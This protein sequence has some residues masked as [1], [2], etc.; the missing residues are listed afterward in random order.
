MFNALRAAALAACCL[1]RGSP[2]DATSYMYGPWSGATSLDNCFTP[3]GHMNYDRD[4]DPWVQLDLAYQKPLPTGTF[5]T[6]ADSTTLRLVLYGEAMGNCSSVVH[7]CVVA[8]FGAGGGVDKCGR[9]AQGP[10]TDTARHAPC[11]MYPR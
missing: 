4:S 8:S 11:Y 2:S 5:G 3:I 7:L 1:P 6:T 9:G 10:L